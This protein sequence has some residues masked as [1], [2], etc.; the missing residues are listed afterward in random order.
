VL[1]LIEVSADKQGWQYSPARMTSRECE[2]RRGDDVVWKT[3]YSRKQQPNEPYF[4]I[5]LR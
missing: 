2:L 4:N 3:L 5:I 1:L